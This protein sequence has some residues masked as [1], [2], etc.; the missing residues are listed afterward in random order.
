MKAAWFED[1]GPA[2]DVIEVGHRD[3]PFAGPGE[4]LVALKAS[5]VN[6]SDVKTRAG[7]RGPLAYPFIV[8]HSDGAGIVE[9][10][11]DGVDAARIGQRVWV[12][13]GAWKRQFGTCAE[14][15]AVPQEM[16]VPLPTN[17]D[18]AAGACLGI[19]AS[20]ACYGLFADGDIKGQTV[21]VTGGAGAVG[22]YAIQL[23]K[24]GG[25]RVV[26]T[27]SSDE[28]AQ[29]AR[30]AG[31]DH[32][33]NYTTGDPA[34][35]ILDAVGGKTVDR[36]VEVEF[37]GNLEVTN[38]VLRPGGVIA[39]YGSMADPNPSLPFYDM[40]F[41]GTTLRM[42]LVYLLAGEARAMVC[43]RV[44]A[45]LESGAIRHAIAA[46]YALDDTAAAHEAVESGKVIGNVVIEI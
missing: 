42:F 22:H 32:V 37:G 21:L 9:A 41:N 19:P 29:R 13:N 46:T 18:F 40:M 35:A 27:V 15:I 43:R 12:W 36:V 30:E 3:T 14:Y 5:G 16:A 4:V 31:A 34:A 10:V 17:T 23:A 26:T 11:G 2:R 33:V 44:N 1:T 24:W 25:A 20:T 45:A 38:R 28:K 6:P 39:T 7:A 8:P